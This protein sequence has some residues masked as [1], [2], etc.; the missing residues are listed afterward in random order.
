MNNE[1]RQALRYYKKYKIAHVYKQPSTEEIIS[2]INEN[3]E[4]IDEVVDI[5]VSMYKEKIK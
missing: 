5:M 3:R 4:K 2:F 1:Y